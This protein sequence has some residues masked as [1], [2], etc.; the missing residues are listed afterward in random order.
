M[1]SYVYTAGSS[2][3]ASTNIQTDKVRIATT[4]SAVQVVASYPNVAGTGTV[5]ASTNSSTV[6]GSGTTFTIELNTGYWIGNATGTTV[7][8]VK[9]VANATSFT[10][11]ANAAVSIGGAG[12]TINPFGV[13]FQVADGNSEI[14][15]PNT[16]NNS[17]IVGQG[18]VISY[19]DSTGD[20]AAPFSVTELGAP[21]AD[22]GTTGVLPPPA[23]N[24][25]AV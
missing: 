17:F 16:V 22:T 8:I 20:T 24:P 10:L 9:R 18:N 5:T 2:A 1:A 23:S 25:N 3:N 15:P 21:H 4:T 7:G 11:T 14:I 12:F 19:I 13:P 6:T